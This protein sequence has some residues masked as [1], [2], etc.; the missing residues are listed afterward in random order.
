ALLRLIRTSVEAA[1]QRGVSLSV[2]GEM[3]RDPLAALALVGLGIRGLSVSATSLPAVRR[4]IR[5]ADGSQLAAQAGAARY[6]PPA[7][8]VR[9]VRNP[10][11]MDRERRDLH[12]SA[13]HEVAGHVVD[14]LVTVDVR[15]VVRRRDRERV[16]VELAGHER[17]DDEVAR[18]EGLVDG[19]RLVDPA[20]DRLEVTDVEPERPEVADPA[21]EVE[22]VVVVVVSRELVRR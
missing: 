21:D 8:G 10:G 12:A 3:A 17:A 15:V 11:G 2:C 14:D 1:E 22:R 20:G 7:A 5:P 19:R 13:A 9:A 16:V 6:D 18:L 4:A